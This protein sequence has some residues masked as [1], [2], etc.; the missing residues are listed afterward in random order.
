M[1]KPDIESF[2]RAIADVPSSELAKMNKIF[3][4]AVLSKNTYFIKA[5]EIPDKVGFN[6]S[7]LC[8]YLFIDENGKESTKHFCTENNLIIS[9]SAS[10]LQEESK[11]YIE[12]LEDSEIL[13][14]SYKSFNQLIESHPCWDRIARR[15]IEKAYIIMEKRGYQLLMEDAETRYNQFVKEYPNL[16]G[17]V[18]HYHIASYL[19]ISPVSLSRIRKK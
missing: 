3:H 4:P 9:Y 15:L 19:G 12:A 14:A 17:R 11:F 6:V 13:A 16:I 2:F 5:G 1:E 8:R 18:K 10:L 7:G